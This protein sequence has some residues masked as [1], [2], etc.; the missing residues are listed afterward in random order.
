MDL[1]LQTVGYAFIF[2]ILAVVFYV[3]VRL[4]SAGLEALSKNND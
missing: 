4:L 3:F 2:G 1:I